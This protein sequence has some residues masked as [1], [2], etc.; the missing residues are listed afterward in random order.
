MRVWDIAPE[1]LCRQHL[2]GEHREIHALWT[3]LTQG[4]KGYANHPETRRWRGKERALLLRHDRIAA[5]MAARG[6]HHRTPLDPA[7]AA[8][9]DVQ[10]EFVDPPE[11]QVELLRRKGCGCQV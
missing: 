4:K 7:L 1:K 9:T 6:Y 8:G 3:I 5:E 10:D 2:L 11:E